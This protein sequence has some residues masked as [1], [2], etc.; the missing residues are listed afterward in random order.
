LSRAFKALEKP[1]I[2]ER[3]DYAE[4]VRKQ[5]DRCLVYSADKEAYPEFVKGLENLI[6]TDDI[7][8]QYKKEKKKCTETETIPVFKFSCGR[9]IGT[10]EN[11]VYRNNPDDWNWDGE[12][13]ILVSPTE[14]EIEI[15]NWHARFRAAFNLFVRLKV[16]V[17]RS[18]YSG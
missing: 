1:K 15:T 12:R 7:D 13:P 2:E 11:P 8:D 16:A 3:F 9:K 18:D 4:E 14:K 17:R 10:V 6:P 5:I